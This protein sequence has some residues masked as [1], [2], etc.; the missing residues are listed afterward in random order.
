[1]LYKLRILL[2]PLHG[3]A[4]ACWTFDISII[5]YAIDVL[6]EANLIKRTIE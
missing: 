2:I 5:Y 1:M 6:R 4:F 3:A